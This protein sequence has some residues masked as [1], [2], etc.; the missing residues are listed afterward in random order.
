MVRGQRERFKSPL[1]I[2]YACAKQICRE[3]V[4]DDHPHLFADLDEIDDSVD[5]E[6]GV[7]AFAEFDNN[8]GSTERRLIR[9]EMGIGTSDN[10]LDETST[11]RGAEFWNAGNAS[12]ALGSG[13]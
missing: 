4:R 10:L 13:N 3:V 7:H 2:G 9:F 1:E 11:P 5:R 12:L 8:D 6:G